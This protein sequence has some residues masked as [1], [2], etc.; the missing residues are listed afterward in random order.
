MIHLDKYWNKRQEKIQVQGDPDNP[1]TLRI[2]TDEQIQ[3]IAR[4]MIEEE[5]EDAQIVERSTS[6]DSDKK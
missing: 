4:S 2:F 5:T 1:I 3:N 6:T